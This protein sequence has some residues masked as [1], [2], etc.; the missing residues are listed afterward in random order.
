MDGN[1]VTIQAPPS[2]G[3][4]CWNYKGSFFHCALGCSGCLLQIFCTRCGCLWQEQW[5]R[6]PGYFCFWVGSAAWEPW[7][8][9]RSAITMSRPSW[10][11]DARFCSWWGIST[12]QQHNEALSWT[13]SEEKS[14]FNYCL[15]HARC[16]VECS[17]GILA[18]QW[19]LYRRVLRVSPEVAV[20]WKNY[21]YTA[22]M[23]GLIRI[24]PRGVSSGG[25]LVMTW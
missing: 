12:T 11:T 10:P 8:P 3:S 13:T 14:A 25:G 4:M 9:S 6:H 18:S 24:W 15:S 21:R 20:C 5:W 7:P 16:M 19:W 1:H 23:I 17:F 2:S 22:Q